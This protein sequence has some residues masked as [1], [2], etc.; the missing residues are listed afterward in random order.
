MQTTAP[1][2]LLLPGG[3]GAHG[4]DAFVDQRPA[5]QSEHLESPCAENLPAAH[6]SHLVLWPKGRMPI[7]HMVGDVVG[8]PV[9]LALGLAVGAAVG[10]LLGARLGLAVGAAV[11][12]PVGAVVGAVLGL[13]LGLALGLTVGDDVGLVVGD[14][15][16][17][18]V[19]SCSSAACATGPEPAPE[20]EPCKCT[21]RQ[22]A[23]CCAALS[24][25]HA[26]SACVAARHG[27]LSAY[28]WQTI[29]ISASV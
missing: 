4:V 28:S 1:A 2:W 10:A 14:D 11:G 22:Y 29:A 6:V 20:P 21:V 27:A 18:C 3:H 9:G 23:P 24:A 15:V 8:L 16:G 26:G 5:R 13:A 12:A 25:C 17:R 7:P 19:S